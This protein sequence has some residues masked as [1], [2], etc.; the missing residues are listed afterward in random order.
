MIA[1]I[2]HLWR[3]AGADRIAAAIA[4]QTAGRTA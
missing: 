2:C 4:K 1:H 3:G